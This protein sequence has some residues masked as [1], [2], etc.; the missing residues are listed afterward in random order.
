MS[1]HDREAGGGFLP[2]FASAAVPVAGTTTPNGV[3]GTIISGEIKYI[4]VLGNLIYGS[5]GTSIDAY[6]QTS[7]DRG[8]SWIDVIE[9]QFLLAIAK[10]V[11]SVNWVATATVVTP[12]DGALAANSIVSGILGDR[13][14]LKLVV[15]GTYAAS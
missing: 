8:A 1:Q 13:I 12:T 7:L 14:R 5:A 6:I 11:S 2:L 9:L 15:V 10:K 4:T 3:G